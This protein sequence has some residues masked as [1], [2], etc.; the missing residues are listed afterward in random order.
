MQQP[1]DGK[2]D[3]GKRSAGPLSLQFQSSTSPHFDILISSSQLQVLARSLTLSLGCYDEDFARMAWM[4]RA[5]FVGSLDAKVETLTVDAD[6][7]LRASQECMQSV[8]LPS[9][10]VKDAFGCQ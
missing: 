1:F 5:V 4:P 8:F 2:Y 9:D 7:V 3:P 6:F 10:E